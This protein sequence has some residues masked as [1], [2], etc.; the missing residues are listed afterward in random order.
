MKKEPVKKA[1]SDS[2][3]NGYLEIRLPRIT[4]RNT[5]I[6]VYLVFSLVIFSFLLGMLTNKVLYLEQ[7][8]KG[9]AALPAQAPSDQAEAGPTYAPP[10][11]HVDV[12]AGSLPVL[13]NKD[14]KVTVVEFSDFECPFCKR[15]IDQTGSQINDAYIKTGKIAFAYRHYPLVSIHPNAQ[16]A[17]E[18]SE[19]AN[20]QDAFWKYHDLL[21]ENQATWSSQAQ[22]EA[23]DAFVSYAGDLGLNTEQFR[24]C[25]EGRKY[26]KKVEEDIAAGEAAQVDGT[27]AFF[28]N[29]YRITGAQPFSEFERLIEQ[30]LKK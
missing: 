16:A 17:A 30:E 26:Q 8:A 9:T 10:P 11:D 27:P 21:F 7:L 18:A 1:S 28:V 3:K 5:S 2:D 22:A 6:N 20:E 29:G 23:T 14:A 19:C 4:F 24:S 13:G 25:F 12:D 15:H